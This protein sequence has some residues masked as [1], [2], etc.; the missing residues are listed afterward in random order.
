MFTLRTEVGR[1]TDNPRTLMRLARIGLELTIANN[2]V[3]FRE[4]KR[5]RGR[6]FPRLYTLARKGRVRYEREREA[7]EEFADALTVLRR[8]W[9]D[10]DDLICWRIAELREAGEN[11]KVVIYARPR[12]R[13]NDPWRMHCQLRRG[14]GTIED[15][16]RF[17]GL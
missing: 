7:G 17:M 12:K 8:G 16:S 1:A 4:F 6:R 14:D 2:R 13:K 10:C 15:P 3:T 11:A 9:G 5:K